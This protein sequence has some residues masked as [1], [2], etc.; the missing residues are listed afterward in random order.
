ISLFFK[1][2]KIRLIDQTLV[3]ILTIT[4]LGKELFIGVFLR[5]TDVEGYPLSFVFRTRD[6]YKNEKGCPDIM[7]IG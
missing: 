4:E 2:L 7:P 1:G 5:R 6:V 3:G